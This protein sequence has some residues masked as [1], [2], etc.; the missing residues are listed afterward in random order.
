MM[1][2]AIRQ[3]L[4]DH[5]GEVKVIAEAASFSDTIE[6]AWKLKPQ[7]I[8]MDLYMTKRTVSED[9]KRA[10]EDASASRLLVI[11]IVNDDEAKELAESYGADALLDKMDL[12]NA[13]VP[14]IVS[15]AF[16][17]APSA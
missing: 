17:K 4:A 7:V 1:R 3:M 14:T 5:S 8:I 10:L 6:L 12:Y 13:L 2:Q 11:S 15:L 16:P 9:V